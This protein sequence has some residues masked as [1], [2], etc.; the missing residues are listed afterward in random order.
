MFD[1]SKTAKAGEG[2]EKMIFQ[3]PKGMDEFLKPTVLC[4][5]DNNEIKKKSQELTENAKS[6]KEAALSIFT[7]VRDQIP[8][9][10]D[11]PYTK[12]SDTLK[13]AYGYCI[14]K[15]NL[16]IA[17]MRAVGIPSRYH[18]VVLHKNVLKGIM[19]SSIHKKVEEKIWYH[20]WCEC[21]LS[22][23]WVA[24]DSYLDNSLY[25]AACRK[26]ILTKDKVRTIDWDGD[27][28]LRT[29]TSWMLEDVGTHASY[30]DV[31]K[32]VAD[33]IK[34]PKFLFKLMLKRSNSYTNK[35]RKK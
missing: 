8:F 28:D 6:P 7:F 21:Y 12:A 5:C 13:K 24:C 2:R 10:L 22:E 34:I 20:P 33:R 25:E 30:D 31:C 14:T 1:P 11:L 35:V 27:S 23:K 19:P 4:D 32:K 17:L 3:S 16:Q 18:Q 29:A 26:G 15:T 9:G